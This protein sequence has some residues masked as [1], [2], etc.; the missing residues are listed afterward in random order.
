MPVS[1]VARDALDQRLLFKFS[2]SCHFLTVN[3][4]STFEDAVAMLSK[5]ELISDVYFTIAGLC[6]R[7]IMITFENSFL[8]RYH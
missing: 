2:I 5:T 1:F 3:K 6:L 7:L 4:S 8:S